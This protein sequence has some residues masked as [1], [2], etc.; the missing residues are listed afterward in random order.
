VKLRCPGHENMVPCEVSVEVLYPSRSQNRLLPLGSRSN[1]PAKS[2]RKENHGRP[3]AVD[4]MSYKQGIRNT[5]HLKNNDLFEVSAFLSCYATYAWSCS[6]TFRNSLSFPSSRAM[7]AWPLKMGPTR[8]C[9][10]FGKQQLELHFVTTQKSE[11]LIYVH[12]EGSLISLN[13]LFPW[14]APGATFI[15]LLHSRTLNAVM[16]A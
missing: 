14:I 16:E 10:N 13:D 12:R 6:P 1:L 15:H 8:L 3:C 11:D 9:Q 5:G 4:I 2:L 7:I